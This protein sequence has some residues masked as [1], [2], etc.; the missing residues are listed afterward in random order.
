M[1]FSWTCLLFA[2]LLSN[3]TKP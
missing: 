1:I 2:G 3:C